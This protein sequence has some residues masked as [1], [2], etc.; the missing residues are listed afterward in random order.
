MNG[1]DKAHLSKALTAD[2]TKFIVY[3]IFDKFLSLRVHIFIAK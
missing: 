3:N 1:L 2:T